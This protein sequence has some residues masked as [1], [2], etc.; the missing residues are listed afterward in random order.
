M[1]FLILIVFCVL[2]NDESFFV[3]D[4]IWEKIY[5][6][7]EKFNYCKKIV[8]LLVKYIVFLYWLIDKEE[9]EDVYF[10]MMRLEVEKLVKIFN[11]DMIIYKILDGI[12]RIFEYMEGFIVVG[13]FFD[14]ELVFFRN[15]IEN[16][17]FIDLIF[18][19]D[20]F[21]LVRFDLV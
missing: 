19:F 6:V 12:E 20:Y 17:V 2:N 5:E 18:D 14:D 3:F 16:G 9:L 13:I 4:E 11:I 21:D 7:V 10:K 15:F 1:G 8:R